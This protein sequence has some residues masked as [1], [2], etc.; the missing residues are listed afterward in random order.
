MGGSSGFTVSNGINQGWLIS[1]V[2][3]NVYTDDFNNLLTESKMGCHI[4]GQCLN[5]LNYA[6]DLVLMSTYVSVL[7]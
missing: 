7:Q 6:D 1:P 2:L 4:A 5:H 3:Y